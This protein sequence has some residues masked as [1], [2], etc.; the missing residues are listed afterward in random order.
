LPHSIYYS[1]ISLKAGKNTV[2]LLLN[3]DGKQERPFTFTY[4]V[5]PGQTLFHTFSSLETSAG[6]RYY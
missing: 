5:N 3:S 6:F 1:R 4:H 2:K